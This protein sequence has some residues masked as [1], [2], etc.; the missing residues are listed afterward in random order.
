MKQPEAHGNPRPKRLSSEDEQAHVMKKARRTRT[1]GFVLLFSFPLIVLLGL[2]VAIQ[3]DILQEDIPDPFLPLSEE[4]MREEILALAP[5]GSSLED[6]L[7]VCSNEGWV[8]SFHSSNYLAPEAHISPQDELDNTRGYLARG[9]E[10]IGEKS[11]CS[12]LGKYKISGDLFYTWALVDWAFD[13]DSKL[14]DIF[15]SKVADN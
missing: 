9:G 4:E 10:I 14:L 1:L 2:F 15:V 3:I 6:V 12:L 7:A 8:V 11:M 5:I 13:A